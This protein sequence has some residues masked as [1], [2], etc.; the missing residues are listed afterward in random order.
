MI[1][2]SLAMRYRY[3]KERLE[4]CSGDTYKMMSMLGGGAKNRIL[5][6]FAA[7][8]MG[9]PVEAGPAEATT[10]GS[11]MQ[12][13]VAAGRLAGLEEG[14]HIARKRRGDTPLSAEGP[15]NME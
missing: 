7:N 10:L 14:R 8:A 1:L 2:E 12:Q 4:E 11:F 5:C 6:D 9:I 13:A 3:S 15:A